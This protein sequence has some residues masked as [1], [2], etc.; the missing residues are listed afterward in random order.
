MHI[1]AR[2]HIGNVRERNEDN[3]ITYQGEGYT[4]LAVADGMGG[5]LSGELAS[6]MAVQGLFERVE[7]S[8][9]SPDKK[10]LLRRAVSEINQAIYAHAQSHEENRGMGTTLTALLIV[11]DN[12]TV[13]HVGDSRAYILRGGALTQL[14]YDHSYVA[15]LVR[16]G[17]LTPEQAA[18]HPGRNLITRAVGTDER[19]RPDIDECKLRAG[20]VLLICSDGLTGLVSDRALHATLSQEED[21]AVLGD[22]LLS[23]ALENGGTDNITLVLAALEEGD[24]A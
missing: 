5:H 11:G 3:Y 14:T 6:Q 10:L 22:A 9:S 19:V 13:A 17:Q 18:H 21:L 23:Q 4:L 24:F 16:M 1:I 12:C 7:R 15:E 20:D 2:A 8:V